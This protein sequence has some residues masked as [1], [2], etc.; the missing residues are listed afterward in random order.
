MRNPNA[1]SEWTSRNAGYIGAE[2]QERL[3]R[4]RVL[5]AGCGLGSVVAELLARTGCGDFVLADGD[6]VEAHNLNRQMFTQRDLGRNKA[7]A[8]ASR[9]RE[10]HP[11]VKVRAV[12][13][14]L[15]A[16]NLAGA[17]EGVDCV[18]DSIDFLD[19]SAIL[20]LHRLARAAG[21]PIISPVAAGWGAAAFVFE[22]GSA[23]LQELVGA[24]GEAQTGE[25]S[26]AALFMEMLERYADALP[27][28]VREVVRSQFHRIRER[29]PCPISQLGSG[30][31]SAAA[32]TVTLLVQRL[33]GGSVPCAPF[34]LQLDPLLG[35]RACAPA[36]LDLPLSRTA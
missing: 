5:I 16:G 2:A 10:I 11:Q 24:N 3:R 28:Y 29:Q 18:V 17:L 20:A 30:T 14:M 12:P 36:G 1:G 9:L 25:V 6:R 26:Y 27:A 15:D 8:L 35:A 32:L 7:E 4:T 13:E 34:M 21:L 23:S 19:A 33:A 22:P 31:F